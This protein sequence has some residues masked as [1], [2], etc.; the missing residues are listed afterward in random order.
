MSGTVR[1]ATIGATERLLPPGVLL[2]RLLPDGGIVLADREG[3]RELAP[4]G[5]DFLRFID[6][7]QF[8]HYLVGDAA[9]SPERPSNATVKLGVV[10]PRSAFTPHAHG[11]EHHVLSL[12]HAACGLYDTAR[13]RVVDVPLTPG[14]L[15]GRRP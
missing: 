8:A 10:A 15:S 3:S 9:A 2:Y 5:Q 1:G 6:E 4:E 14:M 11:G 13:G 7:G 12:G